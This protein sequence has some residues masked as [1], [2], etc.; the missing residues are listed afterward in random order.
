MERVSAVVDAGGGAL[1]FVDGAELRDGASERIDARR[2]WAGQRLGVLPGGEGIDG[3]V[4]VLKDRAGGIEDGIGEGDRRREIDVERADEMFAVNVEIGD[5]DGGV[6]G[7]FAFESEAGLLHARGDE[8]RGE[9]GNIVGDA[10]GESG[11]KVAGSSGGERAAYQRVGIGGKDLMV[12]VVGVVE[13]DLSVGDAVFGGDGGV[14]DLRNADV[15]ESIA[16]ADDERVGLADG[17]RES[18]ARAE[19]VRI[20]GNFAGGWEQWVRDQVRRW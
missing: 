15:E 20:E 10:F 9:G 8:V 4:A 12:V 11:G 18:G 2:E 14:V 3:V 17:I 16:G 6:A 1:E 7:D 19:V 5:G 13:K